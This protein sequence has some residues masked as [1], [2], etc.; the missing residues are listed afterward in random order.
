M[1]LF[2]ALSGRTDVLSYEIYF[3]DKDTVSVKINPR[4]TPI[5]LE[6]IRFF[7]CYWAK[8][9]F[10]FKGSSQ[11]ASQFLLEMFNIINQK[12]I[13]KGYD[14]LNIFEAVGH[15]FEISVKVTRGKSSCSV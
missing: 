10:N 7:T 5:K 6:Y 12:G 1:G 9:V 14:N 4:I 15:P 2:S 11:F 3:D 13:E 8:V